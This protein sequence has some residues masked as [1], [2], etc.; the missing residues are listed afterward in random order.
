MLIVSLTMSTLDLR[1]KLFSIHKPLTFTS[2]YM[3]L[4]SSLHLYCTVN[5]CFIHNKVNSECVL[6]TRLLI[7][8]FSIGRFEGPIHGAYITRMRN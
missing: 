2:Q 6:S 1:R 8:P 7:T 3:Q 4:C 5:F